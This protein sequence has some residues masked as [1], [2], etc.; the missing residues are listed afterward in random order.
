MKM[1]LYQMP[2][3]EEMTKEELHRNIRYWRR[4]LVKYKQG[5][6]L[7]YEYENYRTLYGIKDLANKY[8]KELE[9][10]GA[11]KTDNR[12]MDAFWRTFFETQKWLDKKLDWI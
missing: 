12:V 3:P 1:T 4:E 10:R 6:A 7:P 11:T 8:L 9:R 5:K 2:Q